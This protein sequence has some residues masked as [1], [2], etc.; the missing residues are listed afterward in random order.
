VFRW[1]S[2]WIGTCN[3]EEGQIVESKT[4]VLA[5]FHQF[6]D[7]L[8]A[9]DTAALNDLMTSDYR[10]YNLRGVLEGRDMVLDAYRP[11]ETS[12]EEWEMDD[13]QVEVF[14]EVGI[15][16]GKGYVAGTWQGQPWSHHL[17]FCDIYVRRDGAWRLYL[18]HA[19][20]LI[21]AD[22]ASGGLE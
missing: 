13:L 9:C 3:G 21:E 18:S 6:R 8:L 14:S 16:T 10:G 20:P 22:G 4:E 12:L 15:L 11:G 2:S 5:A 19:T 1:E 17:R 7:A